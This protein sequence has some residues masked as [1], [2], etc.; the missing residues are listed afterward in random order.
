MTTTKL[1]STGR[2]RIPQ[3]VI[4]QLGAVPGS[5]LDW[6]QLPDG[7]YAIE[8]RTMS[9]RRLRGIVKWSGAP[10]SISQMNS[11]IE[12]ASAEVNS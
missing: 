12:I 7:R 5:E 9:V 1:D 3:E 4:E 11:D 10:V 8:A 2:T 6:I